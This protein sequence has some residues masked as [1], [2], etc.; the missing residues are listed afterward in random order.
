[1]FRSILRS[2]GRSGRRFDRGLIGAAGIIVGLTCGSATLAQPAPDNP[3]AAQPAPARESSTP[4][5]ASGSQ[6]APG[7]N[8]EPSP[9][10]EPAGARPGGALAPVEVKPGQERKRAAAQSRGQSAPAR[11]AAPRPIATAPVDAAA[12]PQPAP[13]LPG[14]SAWGPV[15]GYVATDSASATKTNTPLIETPQAVSVVTSDQIEAQAAQNL[16]QALRYT[17]GVTTG[18]AGADARFQNT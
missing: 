14:Q 2:E 10:P 8:P 4:P 7:S 18:G 13:P 9:S 6:P 5:E 16:W 3:P 1:M 12:A 11:R 17:S 15:K